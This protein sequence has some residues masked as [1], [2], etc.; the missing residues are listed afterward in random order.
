MTEAGSSVVNFIQS[1][2]SAVFPQG[3]ALSFP[4]NL[5]LMGSPAL[6]FVTLFKSSSKGVFTTHMALNLVHLDR[7][8]RGSS[9]TCSV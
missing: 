4:L 8:T 3:P 7:K 9:W 5:K 1:G 2:A 6:P